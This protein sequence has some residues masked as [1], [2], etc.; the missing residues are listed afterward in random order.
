MGGFYVVGCYGGIHFCRKKKYWNGN[1][2]KLYRTL[3]VFC[4]TFNDF[5][6]S[7]FTVGFTMA[8]VAL[9]IVF[10]YV[11]LTMSNLHVL[12]FLIFPALSAFNVSLIVAFLPHHSKVRILSVDLVRA[13]KKGGK[14]YKGGIKDAKSVLAS[15]AGPDDQFEL[16]LR[17]R[18]M[19]A[20]APLGIRV[21]FFGV[22]TLGTTEVLMEQMLNNI[23]L[24]MSL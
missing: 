17:K 19:L 23:I 24:L 15:A 22:Y 14:T 11:A 1:D 18:K 16:M 7:F 3:Q 5:N 12:V 8:L 21:W 9:P 6:G 13:M 10:I 20:F 2:I 4:T